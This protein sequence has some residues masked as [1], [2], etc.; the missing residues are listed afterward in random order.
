MTDFF[1]E[2]N[3]VILEYVYKSLYASLL[4]LILT[5]VTIFTTSLRTKNC[6]F[7]HDLSCRT[8]DNFRKDSQLVKLPR[9]SVLELQQKFV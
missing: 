5:C 9:C 7:T 8:T 3:G 4:T 1:C 6:K 2:Y